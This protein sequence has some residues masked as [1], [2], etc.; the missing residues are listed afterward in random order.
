M[1]RAVLIISVIA[2]AF[3]IIALTFSLPSMQILNKTVERSVVKEMVKYPTEEIVQIPLKYAVVNAANITSYYNFSA[4]TIA[5]VE[6]KNT[7]TETGYFR[8]NASFQ[9][10]K[11]N[12]KEST[13]L[14]YVLDPGQT[15]L[16]YFEFSQGEYSVPY[17]F[18]YT[19]L[20]PSKN[21]TKTTTR[22]VEVVP[23][24]AS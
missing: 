11:T 1:P 18:K 12:R 16:F 8:V 5:K 14:G 19:V 4:Y 17:I 3:A 22:L 13:Q 23:S 7:D 21:V 10:L 9:N 15:K 2:V 6:V 24:N 20:P